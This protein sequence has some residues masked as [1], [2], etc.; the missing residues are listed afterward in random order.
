[1]VRHINGGEFEVRGMDGHPFMVDLDKKV[2]SCL[3]FDMLLIPCEHAVAAAMHSKRR[4]DALVSEKFTRNTRAAAYSMSISPTG[5]YMTPAAE[6][7]TLVVSVGVAQELV[8]GAVERITTV[9]PV[10]GQYEKVYG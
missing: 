10:K 5:D 9:P 3:E 2:C 8:G 1:L 4:I 6:A 7:D